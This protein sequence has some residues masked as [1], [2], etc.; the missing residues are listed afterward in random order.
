MRD[1]DIKKLW[2]L[3]AGRCNFPDCE[4]ECIHFLNGG[5]LIVIGEMAHVLPKSPIGPRGMG[6]TTGSD[7]YENR[8]LLC[9]THHRLV[10]KASEG[11]FPREL[12]IS[13][14]EKHE[15]KIRA[16]FSVP[17]YSNLSKLAEAIN[18][19]CKR[20]TRLGQL[21]ALNQRLLKEIPLVQL[22]SY[23]IFGN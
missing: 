4:A 8:I 16:S 3:S 1:I 11:T 7:S 15:E 23:G 6:H 12:L 21:M 19:C 5:D 2:G 20:I 17:T 18:R 22:L 14:K 13:W 9:P 10:D